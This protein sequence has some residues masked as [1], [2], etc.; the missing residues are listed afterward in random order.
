MDIQVTDFITGAFWDFTSD[1]TFKDSAYTAEAL[2]A[3]TDNTYFTDPARLQLFHLLEHTEGEGGE[4]LL[5][6]GF[7][8]AHCMLRENPQ[9]IEALTDHAHPWH[10]SGNE[11]V[12]IQPYTYFP[13]LERD[14]VNARLLRI[15]WN[16][17]DRAA[18]VDWTPHMAMSWYRAA[19]HWDAIIQ[20]SNIQKWLQLEPGTAL[21]ESPANLILQLW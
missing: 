11:N 16:N 17:Y 21:R 13:V 15:R 14:P 5:V 1:L 19:R 7:F 20:R 8:A 12:S 3:H 10:S 4:T 9:N 18:K 2:D 6:D